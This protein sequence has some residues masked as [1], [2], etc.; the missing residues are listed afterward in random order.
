MFCSARIG[1]GRDCEGEGV[2]AEGGGRV[3]VG[4]EVAWCMQVSVFVFKRYK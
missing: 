1:V 4:I 3:M 2:G